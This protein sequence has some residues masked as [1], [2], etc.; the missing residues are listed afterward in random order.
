MDKKVIKFDET[1]IEEYEFHQ[2]KSPILISNIDINEIVVSNKFPFAKMDFKYFI[3]HKD[4]KETRPLC[5][6]FPEMSICKRY[7]EYM[8]KRCSKFMYFMIK[9][10]K[11]F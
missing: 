1:E 4:N 3:G 5:I 11:I 10:E 8:Y 2:D 9:D 6:F 7:S